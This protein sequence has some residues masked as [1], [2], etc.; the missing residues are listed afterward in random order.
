MAPLTTKY[1]D[2]QHDEIEVLRSIYMDE[3]HEEKPKKSSDRAFQI[4][5][6]PTS[7]DGDGGAFTLTFRASL[8]PTY[9]KTLP[10]LSLTFSDDI[11]SATKAEAEQVL[12]EKP[13][14]LLGTEMIFEI[15]TSLQEILDQA[16]KNKTEFIPTL[17]EERANQQAITIRQVQ[18]L[19]EEEQKEKAQA[20]VEKEQYLHDVVEDQKKRRAKLQAG[21]TQDLEA[22]SMHDSIKFDPPAFTNDPE[23]N[24]LEINAVYGRTALYEGPVTKVWLVRHV[25]A[26]GDSEYFLTLK[27]C[28]IPALSDETL[29]KLKKKRIQNL[30]RKLE[31]YTRLAAHPNIVRPLAF[32][33]E[34]AGATETVKDQ[35]WNVMVLMERAVE[36]SLC[37]LLCL[38]EMTGHLDAGVGRAWAIQLLEGLS[39]LHRR[40]LVHASIHTHNVVLEKIETGRLVAKLCDGGY[41][42]DL[43]LLQG[44]NATNHTG[45]ALAYWTAPE[46]VTDSTSSPISATDIWT[47]GVVILQIFFGLD[48]QSKHQSPAAF[49]DSSNLSISFERMLRS[50]FQYEPKKRPS[51]WELVSSAFLRNDDSI[52]QETTVESPLTKRTQ[53]HGSTHAQTNNSRFAT[54]FVQEGRLGKGGYGSVVKARNRLDSNF[55]AIKIINKCTE[56]AL[57]KVLNEVR[58]LSQLNHPNVVRYYVAWKE[59]DSPTIDGHHDES[60]DETDIPSEEDEL[61]DPVFPRSSGGLDFIGSN[62]DRLFSDDES[63]DD[64]ADEVDFGDDDG[65]V[66]EE[67]DDRGTTDRSRQNSNISRGMVAASRFRRQS[68]AQIEA[69]NNTLYIQMEYCEKKTLRDV[70]KSGIYNNVE[71][72]WRY[73]RQILQGLIHIHGASIVHRDLKPENI[74]IDSNSN[75][76]IGDFGLA[77]PGEFLQVAAKAIDLSRESKG[78]HGN[79]T[80]SVGTTFYVAP[81]VKSTASENYD[82]KA[83]M[84]SLGIIFF[85]MNYRMETGME[86]VHTLSTLCEPNSMLPVAF[87]KD[88]AKAK[89]VQIIQSL[90]NHNPKLRPSS[91]DLLRA[92]SGPNSDFRLQ[93]I[94]TIIA[95][96]TSSLNPTEKVEPAAL[97][98]DYTYDLHGWPRPGVSES[99]LRKDVKDRL[100]SIFRRHGALEVDRPVLLP[101]SAHYAQHE[102]PVYKVIDSDGAVLQMPLD[103]TLPNA[104]ILAKHP[105]PGP[106][107]YTFGDVF[108]AVRTG[109][110]PRMLGEVDFDI[111]SYN[112]L[113][114]ALREAEVIKVLDEILDEFPSMAAVQMCY[115]IN[116]SMVLS[117]VLE[118]CDIPAPKRPA[119]KEVISRLHTGDHTWATIRSELRNPPISVPATSVEELMTFDFRDTCDR[120]VSRL[121]S[122]FR[123][124]ADL[125]STFSHLQAISIYL[126][127]F[128]VKRKIYINPLASYNEKFYCGK[129]CSEQLGLPLLPPGLA[130]ARLASYTSSGC[131]TGNFLF[132]CVYDSK[133][134]NV[135]AAGGR[136]DSLIKEHQLIQNPNPT[137]T[138]RGSQGSTISITNCHAVGFNLSWQVLHQSMVRYYK[139]STKR[140]AKAKK[141][142]EASAAS[143][144]ERRCHVLVDS[145][146]ENLLRTAGLQVIQELWA[147]GIHA[148]LA[149]SHSFDTDHKISSAFSPGQDNL[150]YLYTVNIKHE[151]SVKVR[152]MDKNEEY[153][154]RTSEL[155]SWF[156]N[157]MMHRERS[158]DHGRKLLRYH[159]QSEH[160]TPTVETGSNVDILMVA[161]K[162]KKTNRRAIIEEG[163][164]SFARCREFIHGLA[165]GNVEV[166]AIETKDD[167]FEGIRETRLGDADSWKKFIQHAPAG[168]R[169]YLQEVHELLK[170]KAVK[171]KAGFRSAFMYNFRT[172]SCIWY[173]LGHAP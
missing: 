70:I 118:A 169:P 127:R 95:D 88:S 147:H 156:K 83:D 149:L 65:I 27:E 58:L 99:L 44:H 110:H 137:L 57:D 22:R 114:L 79:F 60:S 10:I 28:H 35:G 12:T 157:E 82:E 8:P 165:D 153:E 6:K 7:G 78:G 62:N 145:F 21:T 51:A 39:H 106:K 37:G 25:G 18:K 52:F 121:R 98:K 103:L 16:F 86:R 143:P 142:Q 15:T 59:V 160:G 150:P 119:V 148:E 2:I 61:S 54:D 34:R 161:N 135:F 164:Q 68:S 36:G 17:D 75:V 46:L 49:M 53:R 120:T 151:S 55:Y 42:H 3:F 33:I 24:E 74:F 43:H 125:E 89:Q 87:S 77:R 32:R 11:R 84:F 126:E 146:D 130:P 69:V 50:M 85:E 96:A 105:S 107:T 13:R 129:Q 159:S 72:V 14:H 167:I 26:T 40:G 47:L 134:K 20:S 66:F 23:G 31:E 67:D 45:A 158:E 155:T 122:M 38:L 168:D 5:L 94:N 48:V 102:S 124:T 123:S 109:G 172:G 108:R 131:P 19:Q 113:D 141:D 81:E 115:H 162:G 41:Q 170:T 140:T 132:Q 92:L 73:F 173:D 91:S 136:Y 63:T 117:A 139:G 64:E 112:S 30:E 29:I 90:V 133:K 1:A 100:T 80:R 76:R 111:V 101:F 104:R 71:E 166:V 154:M 9:P 97:L 93:L 56:A 138:H 171:A 163:R 152:N 4:T 128:N 116:H 144:Q